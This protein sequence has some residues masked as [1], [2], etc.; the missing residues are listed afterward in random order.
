MIGGPVDMTW[1]QTSPAVGAGAG[2]ALTKLVT[3]SRA[4][5]AV[6]DGFIVAKG[7]GGSRSGKAWG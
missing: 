7:A 5:K 2:A 1:M 6:K 4:A 3:E